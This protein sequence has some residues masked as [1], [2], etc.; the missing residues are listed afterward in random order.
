MTNQPTNTTRK[1]LLLALGFAT[2]AILAVCDNAQA[3][4]AVKAVDLSGNM[5]KSHI[6]DDVSAPDKKPTS[7][8]HSPEADAKTQHECPKGISP[9]QTREQLI[10]NM[11]FFAKNAQNKGR[12]FY[13]HDNITCYFHGISYWETHGRIPLSIIDPWEFDIEKEGEKTKLYK[14]LPEHWGINGISAIYISNI[15]PKNNYKFLIYYIPSNDSMYIRVEGQD[16]F[17]DPIPILDKYFI[18]IRSNGHID[19]IKSG[20]ILPLFRT[21]YVW[22]DREKPIDPYKGT[23]Y[24]H[25]RFFERGNGWN[26]NSQFYFALSISSVLT[27]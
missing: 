21:P 18:D 2:I 4:E 26:S 17:F 10:E 13:N 9:A 20:H 12:D 8:R 16:R 24:K 25:I 7:G 19:P 11:F 22:I 23:S 27:H 5:A 3:E 14:K 1:L 6:S 15:L